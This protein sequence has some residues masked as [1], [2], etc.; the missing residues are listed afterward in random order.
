[1]TAD[2]TIPQEAFDLL[3]DAVAYAVDGLGK[4]DDGHKI[5]FNYP[6]AGG[7]LCCMRHDK[8]YVVVFST[9]VGHF[10]TTC[11]IL[12][13]SVRVRIAFLEELP[14]IF[15]EYLRHRRAADRALVPLARAA[16]PQ[17]MYD[18]TVTFVDA[19]LAKWGA[20]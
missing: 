19:T 3:N 13:A 16:N 18:D 10:A 7:T 17:L 20:T 11:D 14:T 4:L 8:E 6:M 2:T 1:M 15:H 9:R 5:T 12:E